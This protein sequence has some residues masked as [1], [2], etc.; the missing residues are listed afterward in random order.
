MNL[1]NKIKSRLNKAMN[2]DFLSIN[3]NTE[4]HVNHKNYDGGAHYKLEIVSNA[5][6]GLSLLEQHKL[7]YKALDG[8][9]KKEIHALA[10]KT[11]STSDWKKE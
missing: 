2:I 8:M 3:N 5:F 7:V 11:I 6:E 4:K 1:D 9:I 10:L